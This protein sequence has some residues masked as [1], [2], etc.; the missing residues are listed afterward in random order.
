M[1]LEQHR[2]WRVHPD[3]RIEW[4]VWDSSGAFSISDGSQADN[5]ALQQAIAA[6][7]WGAM[8]EPDDP[9]AGLGRAALSITLSR[10]TDGHTESATLTDPTAAITALQAVLEGA[11]DNARRPP[12]S[13]TYLWLEPTAKP[14][15]RNIDLQRSCSNGLNAVVAEAIRS[16]RL[17]SPLP[18]HSETGAANSGWLKAFRNGPLLGFKSRSGWYLAGAL[19]NAKMSTKLTHQAIQ[20]H[21]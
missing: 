9:D 20:K 3:N 16:G 7:P 1:G 21:P 17:I 19:E 13:G 10:V 12:A 18:A 2:V 8:Q 11:T 14:A 6:L 15:G 5:P 4:A